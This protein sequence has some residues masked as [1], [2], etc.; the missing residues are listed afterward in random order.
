MFRRYLLKRSLSKLAGL[1]IERYCIEKFYTIGQIDTTIKKHN[2]K[3]RNY[4]YF[5]L[6]FLNEADYYTETGF[7]NYTDHRKSLYLYINKNI[8]DYHIKINNF[9][10]LL[11]IDISRFDNCHTPIKPNSNINGCFR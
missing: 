2:I 8:S 11:G 10:K 1:L 4:K 6:L 7:T 5:Q 3:L 9:A